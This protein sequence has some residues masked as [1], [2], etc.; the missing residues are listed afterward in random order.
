MLLGWA[1]GM[2]RDL[3][4]VADGEEIADDVRCFK[5]SATD[6]TG[7]TSLWIGKDDHALRRVATRHH[8][9]GVHT[10][11]HV[12][13]LAASLPADRRQEPIQRLR[14]PHPFESEATIDYVPVFDEPIQAARF[15]FTPPPPGSEESTSP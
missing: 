14:K 6:E 11:E 2:K 12:A 7:I 9:T 15:T 4:Y 5:V 8:H 10:D 3:G 1:A 13:R